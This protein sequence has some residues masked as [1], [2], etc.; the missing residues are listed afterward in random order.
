MDFWT[1]VDKGT[2]DEC[3]IWRGALDR[4]G[5]GQVK[6]RG[7]NWR[8][9]RLAYFLLGIPLPER[10]DHECNNRACVRPEHLRPLTQRQN[11]LRSLTNPLA[12]NA[13]KTECKNGHPFDELNTGYDT[14]PGHAGRYCVTCKRSRR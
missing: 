8:A 7:K 5:Y 12:I 6:Y 4:Y 9:H 2:G 1:Y 13:R 3:W 14:R 10:Q 11:V